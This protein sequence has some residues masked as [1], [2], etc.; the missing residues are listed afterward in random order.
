M[1]CSGFEN[2]A[3]AAGVS[4]GIEVVS[5][6]GAPVKMS[7][8]GDSSVVFFAQEGRLQF[9]SG[10]PIGL[11][12]C[13]PYW[14]MKS[15]LTLASATASVACSNH[16]ICLNSSF[17]HLHFDS[18]GQSLAVAIYNQPLNFQDVDLSVNTG[19][20]VSTPAPSCQPKSWRE[21]PGSLRSR[22]WLPSSPS[23]WSAPALQPLKN[24]SYIPE[25]LLQKSPCSWSSDVVFGRCSNYSW[26][27]LKANLDF[28]LQS[29]RAL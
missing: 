13:Q 27:S 23:W 29:P 1:F 25:N 18:T 22:R 9:S 21:Q 4:S 28:E 7:P 26:P 24:M 11:E 20:E 15:S 3:A 6:A 5:V 16:T 8:L 14:A 10:G 19:W 2:S 17:G 12:S